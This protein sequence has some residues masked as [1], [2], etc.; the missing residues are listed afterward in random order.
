MTMPDRVTRTDRILSA[1]A[2]ELTEAACAGPL[3]VSA[4]TVEVIRDACMH[5]RFELGLLDAS[6]AQTLG[7]LADGHPD[8]TDRLTDLLT[9]ETFLALRDALRRIGNAVESAERRHGGVNP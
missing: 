5:L 2:F 1:V 8:Q 6:T 3:A 4:D 7:L 9:C